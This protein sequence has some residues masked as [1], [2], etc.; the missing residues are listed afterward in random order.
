MSSQA[1]TTKSLEKAFEILEC[2]LQ[3]SPE[4]SFTEIVSMTGLPLGTAHRLIATLVSRNYLSR[5]PINKKYYLGT[6]IAHLGILGITNLRNNS[7]NIILPYMYELKAVL[8]ES[9]TLFTA[10]D[11][12]RVCIERV[13]PDRLL[14]TN[15]RVGERLNINQGASGKMLLSHMPEEEVRRIVNPCSDEFLS[16]LAKIKEQGYSISL[17]EREEGLTAIS[18]PIYDASGKLFAAL[19]VA[20]PNERIL[21]DDLD[22]KV[23]IVI[24]YCNEISR[25]LGYIDKHN[26]SKTG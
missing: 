10:I 3:G 22:K 6:K 13:E 16:E 23:Q 26:K 5:N 12:Y 24:Q 7:R 9:V 14:K 15:L 11:K 2:F 20:G 18:A 1:P 19:S 21:K 4:L 25:A 8:N 17:G